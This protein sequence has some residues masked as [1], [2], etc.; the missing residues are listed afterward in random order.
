[1]SKYLEG[2]LKVKWDISEFYNVLWVEWVDGVAYRK[3]VGKVWK[4]AWES[5]ER[6]DIELV[7]G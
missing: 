2:Q 6:E 5:L 3:G 4:G 7:L 1:M